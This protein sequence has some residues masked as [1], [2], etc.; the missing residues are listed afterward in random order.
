LTI[1]YILSLGACDYRLFSY[2]EAENPIML[3]ATVSHSN[4]D[5]TNT[6]LIN[7]MDL[8]YFKFTYLRFR[9]DCY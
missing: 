7:Y 2:R 9:M 6:Q 3:N 8:F 1:T 4:K 5:G